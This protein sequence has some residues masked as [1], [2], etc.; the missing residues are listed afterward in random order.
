MIGEADARGKGHGTETARLMLDYA[1][2]ARGLTNVMLT[3][4]ESNMA[5]RRA[6]E[7]AGFREIGRRRQARRMGTRRWDVICMDCVSLEFTS[8]LLHRVFT[9]DDPR[10]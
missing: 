1:F 9:G 4:F 10:P 6:S 8:P 5:G 3:V 7:K 2:T